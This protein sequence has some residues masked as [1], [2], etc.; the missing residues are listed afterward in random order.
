AGPQAAGGLG[1]RRC[2]PARVPLGRP[3][4][5][6]RRRRVPGVPGLGT[7]RVSHE[8]SGDEASALARLEETGA[9]I[10][11]GVEA[12]V[13]AWAH[14]EVERLLAAW[15]PTPAAVRARAADAAA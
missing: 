11:V 6:A 3:D 15:D 8:A 1:P 13:P 14:A 2:A 12:Q 4:G 10:V 7:R 9:A 5:G